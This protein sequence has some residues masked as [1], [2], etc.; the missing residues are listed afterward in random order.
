MKHQENTM[1]FSILP[2]QKILSLLGAMTQD[3]QEE[4]HCSFTHTE[5]IRKRK[6]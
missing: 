2:V 4:R 1:H 6:K 3:I 5:V